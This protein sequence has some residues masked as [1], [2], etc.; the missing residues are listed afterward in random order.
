MEFGSGILGGEPPVDGGVGGVALS[1][2]S[3]DFPAK[4]VRIGD[5]LA[6][7]GAGQ[8]AELDLRH[9]WAY[10]GTPT[11]SR[12]AAPPGRE[13]SGTGK[14][15]DGCLDCPGQCAPPG[16]PGRL[17]PPTSASGGP[18]FSRPGSIARVVPALALPYT[19]PS[20]MPW[21]GEQKGLEFV[22]EILRVLDLQLLYA[23][24]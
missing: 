19:H 9:A 7:T 22:N 3:L 11:V 5:T 6:Q 15:G 23:L 16:P 12:C 8:H 10:G 14:L 13:R 17:H 24:F 4:A 20:S 18:G 21:L 2:Q 1:F